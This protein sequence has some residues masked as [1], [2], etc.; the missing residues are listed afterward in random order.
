MDSIDTTK[1]PLVSPQLANF[2][3]R[4]DDIQ[5]SITGGKDQS[6]F[7]FRPNM[8]PSLWFRSPP[9]YENLNAATQIGFD[10]NEYEVVVTADSI[11]EVG[12]TK[13]VSHTLIVRVQNENDN[14]P[15]IQ[16]DHSFM[17]DENIKPIAT[18]TATDEDGDSL[19]WNI[20]GGRDDHLFSLLENGQ[21]SFKEA[22]DYEAMSSG[23]GDND[24]LVNVQVS[25]GLHYADQN[26]TISLNN[27]NDT[28]PVV[29]N[30]ELQGNTPI[31]IEENQEFVLELNVTD[32]DQD[33]GVLSQTLIDGKDS[34]YFNVVG[35]NIEFAPSLSYPLLDFEDPRDTDLDNIY[36]FDLNISDGVHTQVIPVHVE[37]I[38]VNDQ[39]PVWDTKGGKYEVIENQ[40]FIIDLNASDDFPNSII[41]SLDTSKPDHEFF[42]LNQ[43]S[44]ELKFKS[45]LIPDYENPFDLSPV[46]GLADGTY[47]ITVNLRDTDFNST[48]RAFDF[49]IKDEDELPT[50]TNSGLI[51]D[52]DTILSFSS[53]DFNIT[54]PEGHIFQLS[55]AHQA[56]NGKVVSQGG[57]LFSYS[58]NADYFGNDI[59]TLRINEGGKTLDLDI[60]VVVNNVND[61]PYLKDDHYDYIHSNRVPM[62][63][64]VLEN[65][66]SFPDAEGSEF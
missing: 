19:E 29:H 59:F 39:A 16:T 64:S 28:A 30:S 62:S 65:D 13:S 7:E 52:E 34:A 49:I 27:L 63:L 61:P 5:F 14:P 60:Q 23:G 10:S 2:D 66:S 12:S 31:A 37:V 46:N 36:T 24:Y 6:L 56:E 41:F 40:Q 51:L 26:L 33:V 11:D 9:D 44:G 22:P 43:S 42:D 38:N 4:L 18:L 45:V 54:D 1:G 53:A 8:S 35:N 21:L 58:P 32:A 17:R 48:S 3:N 20:I 55:I 25:D 50:Y 57:D 47:E 15:I